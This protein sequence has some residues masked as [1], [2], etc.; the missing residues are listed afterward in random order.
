MFLTHLSALGMMEGQ[1]EAFSTPGEA[2]RT[3]SPR[4]G[5]SCP[6]LFSR[7][8]WGHDTGFCWWK[9]TFESDSVCLDVMFNQRMLYY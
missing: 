8:P 6:G 9:V 3:V 7:W 5:C 2:T 1:S 4:K